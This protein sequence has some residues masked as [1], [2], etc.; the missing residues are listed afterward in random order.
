MVM[1]RGCAQ[2]YRIEH[3]ACPVHCHLGIAQSGQNTEAQDGP[4]YHVPIPFNGFAHEVFEKSA[5]TAA[6]GPSAWEGHI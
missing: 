3:G 4:N 5:T 2:V 1:K 6:E